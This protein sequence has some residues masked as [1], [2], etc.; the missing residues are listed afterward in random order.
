MPIDDCMHRFLDLAK[1]V[2]PSYMTLLRKQMK[3]PVN[4]SLF[5]EAGKGPRTIAR[6]LSLPGD[7]AGCYVFLDRSEPI[8][9]GISRKVLARVRQ[10]LLGKSHFDAS[11]AYRMATRQFRRKN[12]I[13]RLQRGQAMQNSGFKRVFDDCKSELRGLQV[14]YIPIKNDLELYLFEAFCAMEFDTCKWNTFRTH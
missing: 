12:A 8:Y 7:F 11:L 4:A 3:K 1:R 5:A 9:V 2:L 6:E 10:H 14:A 13:S